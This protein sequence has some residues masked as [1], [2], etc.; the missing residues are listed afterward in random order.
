MDITGRAFSGEGEGRSS[1]GK[2]QGRTSIIG[3][4]KIDRER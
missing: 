2:L 1:G 3:R 4:H